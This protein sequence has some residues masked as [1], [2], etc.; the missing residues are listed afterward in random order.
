MKKRLRYFVPFII[1][2]ILGN[3]LMINTITNLPTASAQEIDLD[4]LLAQSTA[5]G[6]LTSLT[7][8]S[9]NKANLASFYVADEVIGEEIVQTLVSKGI[10]DYEIMNSQWLRETVYQVT[11]KL[12][13]GDQFIIIEVQKPE[14]RY[15]IVALDYT[16]GPQPEVEKTTT[17]IQTTQAT[18]VPSIEGTLIEGTLIVQ[19][20]TGGDF[21]LVEA[22]GSRLRRLTNGI[23]PA[24]SPDASKIAFT[25]WNGA[26]IG[27]LLVYDL[28]TGEER[29]ILDSIVYQ[30]KAPA[31]SPDGAEIII[32][33]QAGQRYTTEQCDDP[34]PHLNDPESER[35]P[36]CYSLPVQTYW[37][38]RRVNVE[39]GAFE[40]L[41]SATHSFSPN[42]DPVQPWRIVFF[43]ERAGVAQL[44]L[45]RSV[46][47]PPF[48][49]NPRAHAP[50][51]SPD[52][53][54]IAVMYHHDSF[55]AIYTLNAA[56]GSLDRLGR[57]AVPGERYNDASPVWSPDGEQIA[58]VTDRSGQWEFWVMNAD[59][60]HP[61]PLFPA[62]VAAQLD[63]DYQEVD[64]RLISWGM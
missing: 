53:S 25:R 60:S 20:Q 13:P 49:N 37:L 50:V 58:F 16:D 15:Q 33:Y 24:L 18:P 29:I 26:E 43:D 42:W 1:S 19:P 45:N 31:W 2:L 38:L 4:T 23:D 55:R 6:F 40:D 39:T 3:W 64:E 8:V 34:L 30:P 36:V 61:H 17:A 35:K 52:G 14:S 59:G 21:Y 48:F 56:D 63:V 62:N 51:F 11:A 27:T 12:L 54:K 9:T 47:L 41:P 32:N 7:L 57:I 22:N 28:T 10:A 46:L 44:D 5:E